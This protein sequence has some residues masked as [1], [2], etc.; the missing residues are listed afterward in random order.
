MSKF[1]ESIKE[2]LDRLGRDIAGALED[3]EDPDPDQD[4]TQYF[5]LTPKERLTTFLYF[6]M[7]DELPTG[8]VCGAITNADEA[9]ESLSEPAPGCDVVRLPSFSNL[10]L[11]AMAN[12]Y[13]ERI[14]KG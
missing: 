14:L 12:D 4:L 9:I 2:E 5:V 6:L 1:L 3:Q 11:E 13:A 10:H 8:T 7:R